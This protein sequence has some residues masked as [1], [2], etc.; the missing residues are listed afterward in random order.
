[1]KALTISQPYANLIACGEKQVENRK[2]WTPYRGPLAIHA[3]SG[4]Q[5]LTKS[6]LADYLTGCVIAVGQLIDC[7]RYATL[8]ETYPELL[9]NAHAIGPWCWIIIDVQRIDPVP[10]KGALGLWE[11]EAPIYSP[12]FQEDVL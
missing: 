2:W 3:G 4:T 12:T 10:M 6:E 1:M 5:Y 11:C 9:G 7:V 8:E